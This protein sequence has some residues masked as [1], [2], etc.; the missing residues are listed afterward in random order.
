M[1]PKKNKVLAKLK[2]KAKPLFNVKKGKKVK[3]TPL[4]HR[5]SISVPDLR[6]TKSTSSIID[7][8][9]DSSDNDSLTGPVYSLGPDEERSET[10]SVTYS[11]VG[12]DTPYSAKS[13]KPFTPPDTSN[14]ALGN[15]QDNTSFSDPQSVSIFSTSDRPMFTDPVIT[16]DR[17]DKRI[18]ERDRTTTWYLE[19]TESTCSTPFEERAFWSPEQDQTFTPVSTDMFIIGS[20]ENMNEGPNETND[21][22]TSSTGRE[23]QAVPAGQKVQYL[24]NITLKEGRNLVVRDRSGTSDPY[25][26]FRIGGKTIYKS[27]VVYKNLNPAW[28][29]SF[30]FLVR[31][32][33]Q[34]VFVKVYDRDLRSRD[35]MGSNAIHLS[36]L[37]LDKTTEMI[38]ELEDPGSLE[39]DM[40]V[41]TLDACVSIFEGP[42]KKNKWQLK[43]KGS[44]NKGQLRAAAVQKS[45]VWNGLYTVVLVEG[46]EMPEGG[47][48]DIFVRFRLGEQRFRS[49]NLCIKANPQWREKFEFNRFEDG[50]PDMLVFEVLCK[51]GRKCEECW[52]MH[53]V[54]ISQLPANQTHSYSFATVKGQVMFLVTP[55]LCSGVSVLDLS[56]APLDNSSDYENILEQYSLRNTL[57]NLQEVGYLQVKVFK[58][59]D[60]SST[61]LNG[62]SD[63]F[64]VLELGNSKLQTH[65][66]YKTIHP[67]W[68]A[69]FTLPIKDIHDVLLVSVFGEDGD[70]APDFLGKVALPLLTV[71]NG[72][73]VTSALKKRDLAGPAKGSITLE[74]NI[75]Y[76]TVR[77]AVKTFHPTET[78]PEEDNPKFNKKLLARN[79]YRVKRLSMAILYTLQYIKSCFQWENT[80][81]SIIAF[82]TFMVTVWHFEAFMLPLF[83]LLLI[84]WNYF[85]ITPGVGS[86]SQDMENMSTAEDED[87]DEKEAEKRGLM[88]KIHMVQEIVLTVQ[89]YLDEAACIGERIKNTFNWSIPFLSILACVVLFTAALA[90]YFIPLR[91]FV[92]L[93]GVNKFTKK[94]RNPHAIDSNELLNFLKRVPSDVQKVQYSE[95]KA[96]G[97]QSGQ[98]K[99]R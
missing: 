38:L 63:P 57:K 93:W 32:L 56:A 89:T 8:A 98:K 49:K 21:F 61:D 78:K 47:Q 53:E 94:L 18:A 36:N 96:T 54:D 5:R 55:T 3:K 48:G 67:E 1:D 29:E 79:I 74:M 80:Q 84:G 24:L 7:S 69:T 28:N 76:N 77:A 51:K 40:G 95:L 50:Q 52:G 14:S 45:Q 66:I 30:S 88:E 65:T 26:K 42:T 34:K 92:L 44:F 17:P 68:K 72:Q 19:D 27:K 41:I 97:N 87:E 4:K 86:H 39:D 10:H 73:Q 15:I 20:A 31:D 58:A 81:R 11:D 75:L 83:L 23:T 59:T 22:D 82:L 99:K 70:K 35:F 33:E 64:C 6:C 90:L 25:V 43:R 12:T 60:L 71:C 85:H 13:Y 16:R 46:R 2:E 9:V 37:E 91:Y 62:K